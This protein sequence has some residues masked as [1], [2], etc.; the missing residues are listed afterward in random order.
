MTTLDLPFVRSQFP[1]FNEPSL[2]DFAHFE[3]AGGSYA[4][5][6]A[7]TALHRFYRETKVQP[8]HHFA[9]SRR[10]GE[11]MYRAKARGG[12]TVVGTVKV[13]AWNRWSD[14]LAETERVLE[15]AF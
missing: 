5:E 10:G 11:L 2:R 13:G 6:Q 1:A 7:I 12:D 15:D 8:Y 9:P 14:H 4:C 3:N